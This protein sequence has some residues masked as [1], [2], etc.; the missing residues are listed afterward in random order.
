MDEKKYKIG[1]GITFLLLSIL[2]G[3]RN[4]VSL[5]DNLMGLIA[6]LMFFFSIYILLSEAIKHIK[7]KGL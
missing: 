1:M 4:Y 2:M 3:I 5:G 7:K 6:V